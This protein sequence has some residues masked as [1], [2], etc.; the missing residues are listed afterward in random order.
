MVGALGLYA[1]EAYLLVRLSPKGQEI[2]LITELN[3]FINSSKHKPAVQRSGK[4]TRGM[5][6]SSGP[7]LTYMRSYAHKRAV[8]VA[9]TGGLGAEPPLPQDFFKIMHFSG[10]FK[11]RTPISSKLWAQGSGHLPPIEVQ[12]PLGPPDQNPGSAPE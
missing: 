1:D 10:N 4:Q 7:R 12:S 8:T 3:G 5:L 11:G 9:D 6:N 2:D